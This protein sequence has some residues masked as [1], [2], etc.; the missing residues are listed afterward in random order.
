MSIDQ[1][2]NEVNGKFLATLAV[3]YLRACIRNWKPRPYWRDP[4]CKMHHDAAMRR[5]AMWYGVSEPAL[6]RYIAR[7]AR[8]Q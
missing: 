3:D 1:K 8:Q 2:I 6:R 7:K 5:L 4:A